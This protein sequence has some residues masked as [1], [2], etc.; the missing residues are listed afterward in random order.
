MHRLCHAGRELAENMLTERF[1]PFDLFLFKVLSCANTFHQAT[2]LETHTSQRTCT[3]MA[4]STSPA[5]SFEFAIIPSSFSLGDHVKLN[6]TVLSHHSTP[7]TILT[8]LT[9]LDLDYAQ[10]QARFN[11]IEKDTQSNHAH[12]EAT[13]YG[14]GV[15]PNRE[16]GGT[17]DKYF[18]TLLPEQPYVITGTLEAAKASSRLSPGHCY[19]F[20]LE[21]EEEMIIRWWDGER[22]AI[23]APPGE[24]QPIEASSGK[25]IIL[26][27]FEPFEFDVLAS[28]KVIEEGTSLS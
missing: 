9:I 18:I 13:C 7:I 27:G 14:Y 17:F 10:S 16:K 3:D 12:V 22:E 28:N 20:E 21:L 4:Q 5:V 8:H 24:R 11:Y 25:P 2:D 19:R 26:G 15:F 23:M 6:V 1:F